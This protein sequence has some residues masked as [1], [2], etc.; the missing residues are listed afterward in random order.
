ML[1]N[2]SKNVTVIIVDVLNNFDLTATEVVEE[3]LLA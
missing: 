3:I 1:I 2:K